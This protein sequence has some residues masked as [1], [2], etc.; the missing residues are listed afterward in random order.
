MTYSS[1]QIK[2]DD[3]YQAAE[4]GQ[5]FTG[6]RRH[7]AESGARVAQSLRRGADAR[8]AGL[9]PRPVVMAAQ[10]HSLQLVVVLP[11]VVV[12]PHE[13]G[14]VLLLAPLAAL[15]V[16]QLVPVGG[17]PRLR[18][19]LAAVE[20][21]AFEP[22]ELGPGD[23]LAGR[24]HRGGRQ[25]R[26][27]QPPVVAP[28][29]AIAAEVCVLLE[30]VALRGAVPHHGLGRSHRRPPEL[31]GPG[32]GG[33]AP[34]E[35]PG[36]GEV[37]GEDHLN[38]AVLGLAHELQRARGALPPAERPPR[39]R[40][41]VGGLQEGRRHAA[42]DDHPVDLVQQAVDE[43]GIAVDLVAA[44]DR[45]H[46]PPQVVQGVVEGVEG[47]GPRGAWRLAPGHETRGGWLRHRRRAGEVGAPPRREHVIAKEE[48]RGEAGAG[49][50]S[51]QCAQ[52]EGSPWC[53]WHL[54][55]RGLWLDA[56][57]MPGGHGSRQKLQAAQ[58]LGTVNLF[59]TPRCG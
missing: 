33:A 21:E 42:A 17:H 50:E 20:R 23:P 1:Q 34:A 51:C 48:Q 11:L 27:G 7:V 9:A 47:I 59:T 49:G 36:G 38:T 32:P 52:A 19:A 15:L 40:R 43:P 37:N 16:L 2:A 57:T 26:R 58:Q 45:Q 30:R 35:P 44:D 25:P 46:R 54:A 18:A 4:D 10:P 13:E 22:L 12:P 6:R 8:L 56:E 5:Q 24:V 28:R 31:G 55:C 29:P 14:L 39:G 41:A 53:P 3:G